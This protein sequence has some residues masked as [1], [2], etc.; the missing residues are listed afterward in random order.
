[1][2]PRTAAA[3]VVVTVGGL[4]LLLFVPPT[5]RPRAVSD[6][7]SAPNVLAPPTATSPSAGI[8]HP[9]DAPPFQPTA[10]HQFRSL[11]VTVPTADELDS[12][13]R[14]Q[15]A[16]MAGP[17]WHEVISYLVPLMASYA[18]CL[19][20][21]PMRGRIFYYIVWD[22]EDGFGVRPHVEG[23]DDLPPEGN[24]TYDD[25]YAFYD[26]VD[27]YLEMNEVVHLPHAATEAVWGLQATFP[28]RDAPIYRMIAYGD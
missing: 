4:A 19:S 26:C 24:I 18:G 14:S 15:L 23:A 16:G 25:L 22:V 10:L 28:V 17:D 20:A 13:V 12:E 3:V 8:T 21:R 11:P 2:N 6:S 1:M 9:A 5:V 27:A 7:Q